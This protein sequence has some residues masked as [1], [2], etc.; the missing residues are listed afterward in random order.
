MEIVEVLQQ[1]S[2]RRDR[3]DEIHGFD[4]VFVGQNNTDFNVIFCYAGC[5]QK[6]NFQEFNLCTYINFELS[7]A[8][9][10]ALP[11]VLEEQTVLCGNN[12]SSR[13]EVFCKKGVLINFTKF[14]GK[15]LYQRLFVNKVANLACIFIKKE[16]LAQAFS[17][18][19]CE[20]SKN[21]F[22]T[23]HLR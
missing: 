11:E 5:F 17:C 19:F 9:F 7:S 14:I 16:S 10:Y 2:Y 6:V 21:T 4:L 1:A 3:D 22:F 20:I 18:K 23:E 15:H 13:P 8:F 12:T